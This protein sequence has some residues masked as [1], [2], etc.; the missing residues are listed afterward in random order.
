MFLGSFFVNLTIII[1]I[2]FG[3]FILAIIYLNQKYNYIISLEPDIEKCYSDF[4]EKYEDDFYFSKRKYFRWRDKY[5]ELGKEIL[6]INEY[7]QSLEKN[8][9]RFSSFKVIV[10]IYV[11]YFHIK[12]VYRDKINYLVIVFE[13]GL[14]IIKKRN[15][16]FIE[17]EKRVFSD[18]FSSIDGKPL[19]EKQ[20]E[21]VITE[22][23]NNLV[24][25][26]AGTGKTLSILGKIK[27]ILSKGLARPDEILILSYER[28]VKKELISKINVNFDDLLEVRTFHSFGR[29]I[30]GKVTGEMPSVSEISTD[31]RI[32]QRTI[33]GFLHEEMGNFAYVNLLNMYF[34][35]FLKPVENE[36]DFSSDEEYEEYLRAQQIRCLKG[37]KVKSLAECEIANFLFLNQVPFNYEKEYQYLTETETHRQY[38]P[39]F[40][41]PDY[42]IWIEHIGI[43]H[44]CNTAPGVDR[45][46]Y[47]DSWYWKRQIHKQNMTECLETYGYQ[48]Q[49]GNL[50]ENLTGMLINRGVIFDKLSSEMIFQRLKNLGEISLFVGLLSK[51]LLLFKSSTLTLEDLRQKASQ[52]RLKTR[53]HAFLDIFEP[54][55]HNYTNLLKSSGKIDFDD[56]INDAVKY[57]ER[58]SYVSQFKYI[59]VDEFQDISQSRYRLIKALLNSNPDSKLFC[60]GDDWQ[61][62][63]R[64]AGSDLSI[65]TSFDNFFEYNEKM[66]LEE[67]FRFNDRIADVSSKFIMKNPS[68]YKKEIN[69]RD[70]EDDSVFIV[71]YDDINTALG[72]ALSQIAYQDAHAKVYVLGRYSEKYYKDL[73]LTLFSPD[74]NQIKPFDKHYGLNLKYSTIHGVKGSQRDYVILV[75]VRSG[76]F[77]LPCEIEDDPVLNLVLAEDDAFPY[78]EERRLF[79]VGLTRAIKQVYILADRGKISSFVDELSS[80]CYDVSVLG[81]INHE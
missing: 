4:M 74:G 54:V 64:F 42:G 1:V 24:V 53:Y 71:W 58:G 75:G 56:M 25:A 70:S 5:S 41:L 35:Y 47:L 52:K 36:L 22:E 10:N 38:T 61:S 26:G 57:I 33:E 17:R 18:I 72:T 30:I 79:Y 65:M 45:W 39:D 81:H 23:A 20:I 60:V 69:A 49:E 11:N 27:Y 78:S 51:F 73:D 12:K 43:D 14:D 6:K 66:F 46:D 28:R 80:E 37:D 67:T 62:I 48:H 34:G 40:Y 31:T 3:S 16:N 50:I 63:Y 19:T 21:S 76:N 13:D 8:V 68:Q 29:S 9:D 15:K 2:L 55:Y 7:L 77:G 32:L 44:N 59:L